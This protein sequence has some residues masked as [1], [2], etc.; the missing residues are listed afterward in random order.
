VV[1]EGDEDGWTY[2]V[3]NE[4]V[5]HGV[6]EEKNVMHNMKRRKHNWIYKFCVETASKCVIEGKIEGRREKEE[7]DVKSG[8]RTLRVR[9]DT[10]TSKRKY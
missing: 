6:M 7:E 8:W 1:L 5:L 9:K 10:S 4:D 3:K 2:L